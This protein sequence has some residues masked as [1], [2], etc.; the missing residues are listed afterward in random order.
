[1]NFKEKFI[2]EIFLMIKQENTKKEFKEL[3]RPLIE[4][5]LQELYPFIYISFSL[6]IIIF[7]LILA[8]LI[9]LL[10]NNNYIL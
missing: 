5:I 1:M 9:L 3:F 7:L 6:I 10:K 2:N 4:V 8:I